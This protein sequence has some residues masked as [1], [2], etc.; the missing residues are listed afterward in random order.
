MGSARVGRGW[1]YIF[2]FEDV[3]LLDILLLE[4]ESPIGLVF[5][6]EMTFI[7]FG[8]FSCTSLDY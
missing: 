1:K 2:I 6:L 5:V 8:Y 7:Y 4:S 3:F